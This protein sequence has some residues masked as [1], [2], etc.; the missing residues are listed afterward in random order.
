MS[1]FQLAD[2]QMA[3][4]QRDGYLMVRGLFNQTEMDGLLT[5][6]KGDQILAGEAYLRADATGAETRLAL[7]N[8]LDD[9]PVYT[10]I[11]RSHRFG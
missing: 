7:R 8:D 5:Y 6:A 10:A 11:V 3:Q 2:E 9:D 4:F 1:N